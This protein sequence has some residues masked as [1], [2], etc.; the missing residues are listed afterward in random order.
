MSTAGA[1]N[2]YAQPLMVTAGGPKSS[3]FVLMMYIRNLAFGQGQSIAGMASAMAVLLG[4]VIVVI[5]AFQFI[6]M[7]NNSKT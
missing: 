2:V 3:T 7:Y 4:L 5:S 1:F 6:F